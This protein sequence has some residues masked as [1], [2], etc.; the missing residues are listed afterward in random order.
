MSFEPG[1]YKYDLQIRYAATNATTV[2]EYTTWL[3]GTFTLTADVTQ[4]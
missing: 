4:L 2:P 1:V 3:Y